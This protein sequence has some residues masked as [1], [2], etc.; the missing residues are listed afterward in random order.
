M[1]IAFPAP[2]D[3]PWDHAS[4]EKVNPPAQMPVLAHPARRI[5][6]PVMP[7]KI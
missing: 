6:Y 3:S 2:N 5:V 7:K 4:E 1:A